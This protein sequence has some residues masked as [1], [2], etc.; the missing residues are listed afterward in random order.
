MTKMG[1]KSKENFPKWL[2]VEAGLLQST[3]ETFSLSKCLK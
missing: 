2:P 3:R 1:W